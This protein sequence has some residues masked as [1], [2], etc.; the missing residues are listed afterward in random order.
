M[1]HIKTRFITFMAM[2]LT[3]C[4]SQTEL[5]TQHY[6][7]TIEQNV[8]SYPMQ[9]PAYPIIKLQAITVSD[10]L[11]DTSIAIVT[12]NGQVYKATHY[13]WA[14]PLHT[15]LEDLA[16]R[17]L[18]QRLPQIKWLSP[19][20]TSSEINR[21]DISVSQF[22]CDQYG[23]IAM[24]GQWSLW[25]NAQQLVAHSTFDLSGNIAQDGYLAMTK[26]LSHIWLNQAI[27]RIAK[28]IAQLPSPAQ[29][30]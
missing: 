16:L 23:H 1:R 12:T 15:Q 14:E 7:L 21:L 10:Y 11:N 28:Q 2:V 4:T 29:D 8:S 17:R 19:H 13:Q 9:T 26:Q 22:H 3:G 24:T 27:D 30:H 6:L 5:S 25:N 18:N 20:I